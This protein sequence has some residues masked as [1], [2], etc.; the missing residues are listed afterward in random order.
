ME[1]VIKG[2]PKEIASLVVALQGRPE[3]VKQII[4][5]LLKCSASSAHTRAW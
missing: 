5:D 4:M 1:L 3:D 2:E